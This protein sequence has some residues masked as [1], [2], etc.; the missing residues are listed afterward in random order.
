MLN[1]KKQTFFLRE[2]IKTIALGAALSSSCH[3]EC[4]IYLYGELGVGKTTFCRGFLHNL[5][6]IGNVKSPTYSLIEAY[7][8]VN[9]MVYHFDLYRLED[10]EELEFIGIRDYFNKKTIYLIEWPDQGKGIL[11]E[12]DITINLVR[13]GDIRKAEIEP[14]NDTGSSILSNLLLHNR[15]FAHEDKD[16]NAFDSSVLLDN[17]GNT[18]T[19]RS[20]FS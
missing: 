3:K 5:G 19:G 8:L 2:K 6:H 10:A 7:Q 15:N 14:I 16:Q 1:L 4:I 17:N 9:W 18:R 13:C 12:A 20:N 11:P